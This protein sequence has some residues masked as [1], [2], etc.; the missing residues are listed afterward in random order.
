MAKNQSVQEEVAAPFTVKISEAI[1]S[2]ILAIKAKKVPMIH[3]SPAIGKSSIVYQ[4]AEQFNLFV[5]DMR[6]AQCDPT[7]LNA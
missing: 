6:L 1:Q 3:G 7:D 2:V 4:I 5:I